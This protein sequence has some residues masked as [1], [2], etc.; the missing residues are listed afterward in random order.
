MIA[1]L[2]DLREFSELRQHFDA[3]R[4]DEVKT[5]AIKTFKSPEHHDRIEWER[6]KARWAGVDAVL[7]LPVKLR[8]ELNERT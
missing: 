7:D 8:K 4:E 6:L 5:L 2:A 1:R 3:I